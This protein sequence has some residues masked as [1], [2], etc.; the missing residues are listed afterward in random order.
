MSVDRSV[1]IALNLVSITFELHAEKCY[2]FEELGKLFSN[3]YL[4]F[5]LE[6]VE[7]L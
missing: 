3:L 5:Q 4:L 2:E 1:E 6:H 7:Q